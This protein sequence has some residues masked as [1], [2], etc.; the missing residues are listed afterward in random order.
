MEEYPIDFVIAWIDGNDPEWKKEKARYAAALEDGSDVQ[1]CRFRDWDNLRYWFRGVEKFAPWVHKVYF[2]TCG[3]VPD[4]LDLSAEKLCFVKHGDYMPA[5]YLPTFSSRPIELNLHRIDG[6]QEHFVYFNDDMFL[7]QPVTPEFF[8][9]EGVPVLSGKLAPLKTA[10]NTTYT[11][12]LLNDMVLINRH[13]SPGAL[14]REARRK[15]RAWKEIGLRPAIKNL[16]FLRYG[17]FPKFDDD[18]LPVP[19]LKSTMEK[20][21]DAEYEVLHETSRHR[22]RDFRDVNQYIFRYWQLATG[23]FVQINKARR[24]KYRWLTPDEY[25]AVCGEIADRTWPMMCL[26]D[27]TD[28]ITQEQFEEMKEAVR[29]AFS[30]ILPDRSGFEK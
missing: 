13:F 4:W 20:L 17:F 26:N 10:E 12:T 1:D 25:Q 11:H 23:Q 5:E 27:V 15:W 7:T 3:H 14:D 9:R 28:A 29:H 22:F 19:V 6:L 2:V 18:H 30:Q 24:G 21:W 8:F 16:F